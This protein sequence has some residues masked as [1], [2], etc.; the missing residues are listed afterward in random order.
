VHA[1]FPGVGSTTQE[2]A[3]GGHLFEG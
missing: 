2:V 1:E 3:I